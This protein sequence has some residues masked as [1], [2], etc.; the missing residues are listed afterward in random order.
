MGQEATITIAMQFH[1]VLSVS[2]AGKI[3]YELLRNKWF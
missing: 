3:L 1:A 2:T